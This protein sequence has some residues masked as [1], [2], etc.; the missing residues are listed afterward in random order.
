MTSTDLTDRCRENR[1]EFW[2]AVGEPGGAGGP[3]GDA[4]EGARWPAGASGYVR[5]TTVHSGIVATDGLS[6]PAA[7]QEPGTAPGLGVEL[8]VE[9]TELVEQDL[10]EARWLVTALEEAAGAIAGAGESLPGALA[11]HG[12]LS[13]ELSGA[14]APE[15]WAEDGRLGALVGVPLPG[16]APGFDVE[17][18]SVPVLTF[19]PLRP[20]ELAVIAAEGPEGRRRVADALAAQGWYSY[21]DT[22]RPPVM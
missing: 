13:L 7:E 3:V 21:A 22:Q 1:A 16:R 15:G 18:A 4:D 12:L 8:Y 14:D 11:E 17:G 19:S 2:R 10:G 6:D 5:V 20:S 9:S